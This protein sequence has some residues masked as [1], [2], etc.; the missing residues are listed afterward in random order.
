MPGR[1]LRAVA[2]D[3][4]GRAWLATDAGLACLE[5]DMQVRSWGDDSLLAQ[6]ANAL[7][8]GPDGCLYVGGAAGVLR[9]QIIGVPE[10]APPTTQLVSAHHVVALAWGDGTLWWSD[11][12]RVRALDGRSLQVPSAIPEIV[13]PLELVSRRAAPAFGSG[14]SEI[15]LGAAAALRLAWGDSTVCSVQTELIRRAAFDSV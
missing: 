6:P 14:A 15:P 11:G 1:E 9:V 2:T 13:C 10:D 4:S 3:A 8:A 5:R 12:V 7:L